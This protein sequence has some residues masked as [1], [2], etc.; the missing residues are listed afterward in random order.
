MEELLETD[1]QEKLNRMESNFDS[2]MAEFIRQS[3]Y[4]EGTLD[5]MISTTMDVNPEISI[6]S[7]RLV[8]TFHAIEGI[9]KSG[10]ASEFKSL[11]YVCKELYKENQKLKKEPTK[12]NLQETANLLLNSKPTLK[13]KE[14]SNGK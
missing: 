5:A 9:C 4:V 11:L 13:Q 10:L 8:K 12:L 2:A 3:G 1:I 14:K 6:I 7:D